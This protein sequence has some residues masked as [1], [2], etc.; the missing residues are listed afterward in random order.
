MTDKRAKAIIQAKAKAA[1]RKAQTPKVTP[2]SIQPVGARGL[3]REALE[4]I[5]AVRRADPAARS[6]LEVVL[7]YPGLHAVWLHRIAHQM[8]NDGQWLRARLLSHVGRHYTGI[9]IHP[10]AQIGRRVFIDHGMGIVI[11]ETA[12]VGDDCLIYAGVVLGGT[13]L[14]RTKRHPTLGKGVTVGSNA[15]I[16]GDLRIGDG[17]R[18]GSGSV[19][20]KD[21]AEGATVVGIPGRV[22][23]Q[24]KRCGTLGVPDLDHAALPDPI[25]RIVKDLLGQ[26]ERL[27]GRVESLEKLLDLSPEEL[28][29]ML[30]RHELQDDVDPKL[31]AAKKDS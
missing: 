16:L 4:D 9:E 1:A 7:A 10:G 13:S 25:Q 19:V 26:I 5:R 20:I 3:L 29:E 27:C 11:G 17:A 24:Q 22:V 12:V 8:W 28:D 21:V 23:S 18:V 6:Q 2:P 15:C 30:K 14:A 31:V